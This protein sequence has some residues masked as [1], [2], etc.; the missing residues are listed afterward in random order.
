MRWLRGAAAHTDNPRNA[1]VGGSASAQVESPRPPGFAWTSDYFERMHRVAAHDPVVLRRL[2]QVGHLVRSPLSLFSP[3][4]AL[5]VLLGAAS[6]P[7]PQLAPA[8][9]RE[10]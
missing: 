5:R 1:P 10:A 4:F 2:F 8:H 9:L 3:L 7:A 6:R